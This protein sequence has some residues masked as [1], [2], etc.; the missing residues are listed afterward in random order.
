MLPYAIGILQLTAV[1][2]QAFFTAKNVQLA[3][4]CFALN[5][6]VIFGAKA[7]PPRAR[8]YLFPTRAMLDLKTLDFDS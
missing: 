1:I 6:G 5:L 3:K 4:S 8:V 2:G 7:Q